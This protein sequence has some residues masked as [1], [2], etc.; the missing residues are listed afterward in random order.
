MIFIFKRESSFPKGVTIE[1]WAINIELA[2]GDELKLNIH[3]L[4]SES[5]VFFNDA[6]SDELSILSADIYRVD[7]ILNGVD[8]SNKYQFR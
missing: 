7:V 5:E 4:N 2:K 1:P 6:G 3:G 8:L